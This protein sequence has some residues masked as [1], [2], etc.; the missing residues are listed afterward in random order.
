MRNKLINRW[1]SFEKLGLFYKVMPTSPPI[2]LQ[3]P[4]FENGKINLGKKTI[5]ID[6]YPDNVKELNRVFG[7]RFKANSEKKDNIEGEFDVN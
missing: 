5:N 6:L 7:T 2:L 3:A 4:M 1:I